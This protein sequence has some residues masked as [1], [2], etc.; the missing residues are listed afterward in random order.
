MRHIEICK[1]YVGVWEQK[2]IL[3]DKWESFNKKSGRALIRGGGHMTNRPGRRSLSSWPVWLMTCEAARSEAEGAGRQ[4]AGDPLEYS[5]SLLKIST[6]V[7]NKES[8]FPE[9]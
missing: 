3:S 7:L 5:I 6:L 9:V 4:L 8:R 1:N 2:Y